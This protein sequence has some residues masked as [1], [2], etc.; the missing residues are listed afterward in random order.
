[1]KL[2]ILDVEGT[3]EE[4]IINGVTGIEI[5]VALDKL[6]EI[7]V[8]V[9]MGME[10]SISLIGDS[11]ITSENNK[12]WYQEEYGWIFSEVTIMELS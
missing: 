1:M 6:E 10:S 12:N 3:Q 9:G 8:H 2:Y 7:L 5:R 4:I 11:Y